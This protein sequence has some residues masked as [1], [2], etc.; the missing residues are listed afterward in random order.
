MSQRLISLSPDLKQLRDEGYDI[1]VKSGHLLVRHVPY[2][3]AQK[4]VV[5]GVVVTNLTTAGERTTTPD[6]HVAYL[7]GETPCHSDGTTFAEIIN[8]SRH[9]ELA[10][11]VEVDHLF[12]S[13]PPSG[14]YPDYYAKVTT[15]VNILMSQA[16]RLDPDVTARTFPVIETSE[17]ESPFKYMDT[18]S[19]RAGIGVI[20]AKL[21]LKKV[22]IV[23][24]GGTGSYILDLV[25]KTPVKE[26]HLFDGDRFIS[27]NA[28]RA[29]GAPTAEQLAQEPRKVN[30]F[31]DLYS[32]M[33]WKVIA[34][35]YYIDASNVDELREMDF[36]FL[37]FDGAAKRSVVERLI[38]LEIPF[39]DVG[40]GLRDHDGSIDGVLRITTGSKEQYAHIAAK[41]RI[42]L[43]EAGVADEYA[44]NI[45]VADLNAL[46]AALAVIKWKKLFG[47]Y[48][49]LEHEHH[50]TYTLNGNTLTNEDRP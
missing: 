19:S 43:T 1:A 20:S 21:E 16:A 10:P 26:I 50:S 45:Q 9:R 42:P 30:F 14:S 49:D 32:Q 6:S 28:F 25:A 7:T 44:S 31:R 48:L 34:H 22:A 5:Y 29:P 37:S 4:E 35:D 11:G 39:V 13:K 36:V 38:E 41:S 2:V 24:V 47:F 17:D 8:E 3:N 33:R 46:N 23:G 27:H 18:A 12:S 15:Y 40:M